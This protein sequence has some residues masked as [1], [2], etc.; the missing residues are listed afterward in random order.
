MWPSVGLT[1]QSFTLICRKKKGKPRVMWSTFSQNCVF[2][3]R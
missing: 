3:R 2:E 1:R